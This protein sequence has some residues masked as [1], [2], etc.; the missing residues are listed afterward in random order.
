TD[1]DLLRKA[2][3]A[4]ADCRF[5]QG[6]YEEAKRLY[7]SLKAKYDAQV[8]GLIARKQLYLCYIASLAPEKPEEN[9]ELARRTLME[10]RTILS[11]LDESAFRGRPEPETRAALEHWLK[12]KEDE[13]KPHT[14][15]T[16][17]N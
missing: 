3:F 8:E 16:R 2:S 9:L 7:I 14:P 15:E 13:L 1:A 4:L 5:D 17:T 6:H 10:M 11:H 12:R